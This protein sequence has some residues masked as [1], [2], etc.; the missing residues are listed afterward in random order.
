MGKVGVGRL[1]RLLELADRSL[2]LETSDV[3]VNSL[4]SDTGVTA[5]TGGLRATAGG[6]TVTAGPANISGSVYFAQCGDAGTSV[7]DTGTPSVIGVVQASSGRGI[8]TYQE[9]VSLRGT[10]NTTNHA[11]IC[12]LSKTLPANAKI[13]NASMVVTERSDLAEVAVELVLSATAGTAQASAAASS[14]GLIDGSTGSGDLECGSSGT[15]GDAEAVSG[16]IDV[17]S[18]TSVYVCS[19]DTSNTAG[20]STAGS[21]I[22]TITYAGSAA[23][24]S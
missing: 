20:S 11:V 2:D 1:E 18:K 7:G 22:V 8:Y 6:L 19:A 9:E 14:T 13:L 15:D 24:A 16:N 10:I 5:T 23:P 3:T 4:T 17:G 21:V 12:E